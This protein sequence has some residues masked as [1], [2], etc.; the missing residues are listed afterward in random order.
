MKTIT[1]LFFTSMLVA[2]TT[3]LIHSP[4]VEIKNNVTSKLLV[5]SWSCRSTSD[6]QGKDFNFENKINFSEDGSFIGSGK[7]EEKIGKFEDPMAFTVNAEGTW[8]LV[9]G[10]LN[11]MT[12]KLDM[13]PSNEQSNFFVYA[14][15]RKMP[16]T[17]NSTYKVTMS[18]DNT[19]I[20]YTRDN[21][22]MNK[23]SRE[24]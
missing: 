8:E 24:L 22:S 9:N 23:C 6:I 11:E 20:M 19:L 16:K 1:I 21:H 17:L 10:V 3:T 15:K 12:N 4:T 14:I 18:D 2:C 5:G 7:F 13:T